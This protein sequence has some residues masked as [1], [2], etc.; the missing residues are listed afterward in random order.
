MKKLFLTL[1]A[2][3][4]LLSGSAYADLYNS[5]SFNC[6]YYHTSIGEIKSNEY[7]VDSDKTKNFAFS[8]VNIDLT[9]KKSLMVGNNGTDEM[10][11]INTRESGIHF[12]QIMPV[13]NMT[14]TTIYPEEI[15]YNDLGHKLF[16]SSH[17]RHIAMTNKSLPQQFYGTC[18]KTG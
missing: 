2:L 12:L 9:T 6:N 14:M 8:I 1:L 4:L 3:G 18:A 11:V 15:G 10:T 17:S 13:G 7:K 16:S 5:K